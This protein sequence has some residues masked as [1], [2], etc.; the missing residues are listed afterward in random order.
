MHHFLVDIETMKASQKAVQF[1]DVEKERITARAV[2]CVNKCMKAS[3]IHL[4]CWLCS[5]GVT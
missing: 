5:A 4:V 1:Q 2:Q 3:L